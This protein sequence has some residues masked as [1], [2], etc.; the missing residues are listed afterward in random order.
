MP[1]PL[2]R[3]EGA[4][5]SSPDDPVQVWTDITSYV[6]GQEGLSYQRGRTDEFSA[7]EPGQMS[8][9][10]DNSTGVFT[11]GN[12]SSPFY[13]GVVPLVQLRLLVS[14][15]GI[16]W[17]PRFVGHVTGWPTEFADE[18][19]MDVRTTITAVDRLSRLGAKRRLRAP[20]EEELGVS[21]NTAGSR[22]G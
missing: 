4:F 7:V 18:V 17:W 13:P 16:T 5:G 8:V 11:W 15:D 21:S 2:V 9:V 1:L 20:L 12:A 6:L 19:A 10:L 22:L 14:A 3:L